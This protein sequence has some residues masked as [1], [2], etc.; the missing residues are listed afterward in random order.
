MRPVPRFNPMTVKK[1][2]KAIPS[3]ETP[4]YHDERRFDDNFTIPK[5]PAEVEEREMLASSS[6]EE[7][8]E[9]REAKADEERLR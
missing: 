9:W 8:R 2:K 6:Y 7:R 4:A 1:A 3:Q 5:Y